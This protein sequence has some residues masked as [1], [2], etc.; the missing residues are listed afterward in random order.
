M[1]ENMRLSEFMNACDEWHAFWI[2]AFEIL[3]PF[4]RRYKIVSD[5]LAEA[6]R[7]EHHYYLLGR[8]VGLLCWIGIAKLVTIIF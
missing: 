5:E 4:P 2:G 8:V 7:K 6:L 3:C 1:E